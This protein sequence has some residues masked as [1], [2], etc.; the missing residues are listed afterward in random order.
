M[1]YKMSNNIGFQVKDVNE[2]KEFY[3][4]VFGFKQPS[5]SQVQEIEFRT[6]HH[7]IFLIEGEENLGPVL[8]IIVEDLEEARK[9]LLENHFTIVRWEG[10]GNDCYV[11]DPYGMIYNLW[12]S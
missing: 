7:S 3:E 8:E 1:K 6:E 12:E 10:K 2:A 11:R 5:D 9:H 4:K